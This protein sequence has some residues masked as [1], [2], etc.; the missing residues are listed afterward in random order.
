MSDHLHDDLAAL[1]EDAPAGLLPGVLAGTGLADRYVIRSS[2]IGEIHVA[3]NGHGVSAID[4]ADS[5]GA[6]EAWFENRFG[7]PALAADQLPPELGD[8]LDR[9]IAEG[10]P[11]SLPLDLRSLTPFQAQVLMKTAEIP[12]GEVRP[13]GWVAG[14]IGKPSATRAVGSALARNPVPVVIPCHRVVRSDGVLGRYSMG[15]DAN[16]RRLLEAEGLDMDGFTSLAG[17]GIRLI[18]SRTTHIYCHPTCR[19][20]RRITDRHRAEFR[21]AAEAER[22]GFRACKRCR[23]AAAA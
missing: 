7:R 21:S 17:R 2:P 6:F 8:R 14:E 5:A 22:Q 4:V 10:R 11:G 13:Y 3:F 20:A 15:E 1:R 19:D 23:P 12:R 18:G 16:K 9:A